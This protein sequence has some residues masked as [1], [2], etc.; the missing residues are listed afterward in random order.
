MKLA[1]DKITNTIT[2]A[3]NNNSNDGASIEPIP[4]I[5]TSVNNPTPMI[6]LNKKGKEKKIAFS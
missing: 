2:M 5:V 3:K 1:I 6:E 4:I